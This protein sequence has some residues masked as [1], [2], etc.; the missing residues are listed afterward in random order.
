MGVAKLKKA[1]LYYHK[2]VREE[3]A[4]VL[5][6][7]GVCQV[8]GDPE[9]AA[10]PSEIEARL[11][12]SEERLSDIRYLMRTLSGRYEDPTPSLDRLLGE[13]PIVSMANLDRLARET[14]LAGAAAAV[15]QKEQE[16]N[17]LR[18]EVTQLKAAQALISSLDFFPCPLSVLT[19]GTRTVRG[20]AGTVKAEQ[21]NTFKNALAEFAKDT[22]V[23][24]PQAASA[25]R[26]VQAVVLFSRD[27]GAQVLEACTRS[28]MSLSEL[29]PALKGTVPEES[30]ALAARLTDLESREG[31]LSDELDVLAEKWM[32]TVQKLSDYW[33]N[34]AG[35]YRA[36]GE[37][38]ATGRTLRTLFWVSERDAAQVQKRLEA[39]SPNVALYLSDPGPDDEPPALLRNGRLVRPFNVLT[40]LY[41]PPLYGGTDP[42]PSLAPF[43][44]I[45]FGMCLGDAGYALVMLGVIGWLFKKYRRIPSS[46]K[47]F[48]T[49]FGFCAV[50]T[51][52][53]GV[54]S[55]SFFGNFIDSFLPFLVPLKNSLMLVD[56]MTNPMQV[57]G[58]SLFLGVVHLMLGLLIAAYD[59]IRVG[60]Y[61]EAVGDNIAWFLLV[62]GFCGFGTALGGLLPE[63]FALPGKAVAIAGA[64]VVFLYA[65]RGKKGIFS[66]ALSGFLALYGSTSYLG[67]ILSYSRLLALGLASAA[68]GVI[69][70]ML[71]KL[72]GD[73]PYVGWII[74]I[75]I[76]IGG[77]IFSIAV[78]VLGAFVHS[79]RLQYVEYFGKFYSGG[80][81]LFEPLEYKTDFITIQAIGEQK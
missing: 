47:D 78:N 50:S 5:Q 9:R 52:V 49:L 29:P 25:S 65:G 73:F 63:S 17:E 2:S 44:F 26:E 55:G 16:I 79:L 4:E 38:D 18:T 77:H 20:V 15:R 37:S 13:R 7:S 75:L 10:R 80:G 39:V 42:T 56:P 70:N 12:E 23:F 31:G 53:Y 21:F 30:A 46:V 24:S 8:I 68:V 81:V 43:F 6:D 14:D 11:S 60:Q 28:G 58:I 3:I 33:S 62:T 36:Q 69:I 40:T 66:K 48:V 72:A 76:I 41:S 34:L 32:P 54:F 57:L 59:K 19:E 51:F 74:A 1:E 71:A 22:E 35:R 67:D 45:F 61:I 64:V 27:R